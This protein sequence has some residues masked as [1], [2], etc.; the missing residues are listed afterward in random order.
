MHLEMNFSK[1]LGIMGAQACII[2]IS[3]PW[4][5]TPP[6]GLQ[7]YGSNRT[8]IDLR[9]LIEDQVAVEQVSKF[10][11]GECPGDCSFCVL[12][13]DWMSHTYRNFLKPIQFLY[14]DNLI[15]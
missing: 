14:S 1:I 2:C 15:I 6:A 13:R 4:P 5:E 7:I 8:G 3:C 10:L 11:D 12:T 9:S